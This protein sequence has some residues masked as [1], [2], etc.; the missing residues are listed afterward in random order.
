MSSKNYPKKS[1]KNFDHFE[2]ICFALKLPYD[3]LFN[4]N[5]GRVVKRTSERTKR[6][7][8]K[9]IVEGQL[10]TKTPNPNY[11]PGRKNY[12]NLDDEYLDEIIT[13]KER[14]NL[15]KIAKNMTRYVESDMGASLECIFTSKGTIK[16]QDTVNSFN[17]R[18]NNRATQQVDYKV[19]KEGFFIEVNH[20]D[21][22]VEPLNV[23][24]ENE[25][26]LFIN[27]FNEELEKLIQVQHN[28]Y[29]HTHLRLY[30]T[31]DG[32]RVG[33]QFCETY[34]DDDKCEIPV[35]NRIVW[36]TNFRKYITRLLNKDILDN[37]N[38]KMNG[39]GWR[40]LGIIGFDTCIRHVKCAINGHYVP[41]PDEL[42]DKVIVNVPN[43]D[44]RCIQ[45]TVI[46]AFNQKIIGKNSKEIRRYNNWWKK[47]NQFKVQ[48]HTILEFEEE[49]NLENNQPFIYNKSTLFRM[50]EYFDCYF[51]V[52][53][54]T[55]DADYKNC[56]SKVVSAFRIY[57]ESNDEDDNYRM[58]NKIIHNICLIVDSKTNDGH[59]CYIK[60][61]AL[62]CRKLIH[63]NVHKNNNGKKQIKCEKCDFR[64][65]SKKEM[66]IHKA[67]RHPDELTDS[68]RYVLIDD[69]NGYFVPDASIEFKDTKY[70]MIHPVMITFD[71]ETALK[72]TKEGITLHNP[73]MC[74][75]YVH[76]TIPTVKSEYRVFYAESL[77]H[78]DFI[79][80]IKYMKSIAYKTIK[81]VKSV[82]MINLDTISNL[83][84]YPEN[85]ERCPFCK[86]KF[87][88]KSRIIRHYA[89]YTGYYHNGSEMRYYNA[90]DIICNCC[91]KCNLQLE[92]SAMRIPVY[93]HN[94]SGYDNTLLI[95]ILSE[96][97]EELNIIPTAMDHF[98]QIQT[99]QL[100]FKDS[101][102]LISGSLRSLVQTFLGGDKSKYNATITSVKQWCKSYGIE[103]K[104]NY[105]DLLLQ[106]EPMFYNLV[107]SF[108]SLSTPTIPK[109]EDIYNELTSDLMSVEDYNH[110]KKLWTTFEIKNWK[111][112]Y[113]LYNILDATL[114]SDVL[115][116]FRTSCI[117]HFYVD[118]ANYM[119][120]PQMTYS[121]FL[122]TITDYHSETDLQNLANNWATYII[123]THNNEGLTHDE[124]VKY[125][126]DSMNDFLTYGLN[127]LRKSQIETF[128]KMM[129]SLRGG[130]TQIRTRYCDVTSKTQSNTGVMNKSKIEYMDLN[131]LYPGSMHRPFPYYVGYPK[132]VVNRDENPS[133]ISRKCDYDARWKI[134][135]ERLKHLDEI[136]GETE[137]MI[138][139]EEW[140]KYLKECIKE[141]NENDGDPEEIKRLEK[142]IKET[143][144]ELLMIKEE[145]V[146]GLY[147]CDESC[148]EAP[149][150]LTIDDPNEW[151]LE[152]SS[153]QTE[154]YFIECDIECP[155]ELHN[156][157]ND[158]P[159]FPEKNYGLQSQF[160]KDFAT[161]WNVTNK[162]T[163]TKKL[164][165]TLFNKKHYYCHYLML[166][167]GVQQGYR[168]TKI[169]NITPFKQAPFM[170]EYVSDLAR[171]RALAKTDVEKQLFK[172]LGNSLYGKC[173]YLGLN[174]MHVNVC[175]TYEQSQKIANNHSLD[176]IQD[177]E[178]YDKNL[179]IYKLRNPSRNITSPIF[180]GFTV[181]E[182]SKYIVYDYYYNV[183]KPNFDSV[184][185][186]GQ[187]TDSLIVKLT[188]N[189]NDLR[190]L[191][192]ADYMDFSEIDL[193]SPFGKRMTNYCEENNL[194]LK[195][196]MNNN[197]KVPGNIMKLEH[198]GWTIERFI[199]LRPKLYI[200]IDN[201]NTIHKASKGVPK[202]A[203][204]TTGE[205]F[206][207]DIEKYY[208]CLFPE[209][210][211]QAQQIGV[212]RHIVNQKLTLKTMSQEKC[213]MNCLDNKV[214]ICNDN[215]TT[216][217]WGHHSI[218]QSEN[219]QFKLLN[220][221]I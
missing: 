215:I 209:S 49:F 38:I 162:E 155:A 204:T 167:L 47:P 5:T 108:E 60:D 17:T 116:Q 109:L 50:E 192:L 74:S 4:W 112:Y 156:K 191:K 123:K 213:M 100:V 177:F 157:F 92:F 203:L 125:Y 133:E 130:I 67:A 200:L 10:I 169:H 61:P 152:Q 113:E 99:K 102:K 91:N 1:K 52:Y 186:L 165:C 59:A 145:Y 88:D 37:H 101:K 87:N 170:Y 83:D 26:Q 16:T 68:D 115:I 107:D 207:L 153:F 114:L 6:E 32:P 77:N 127:L 75:V 121:L 76:S 138:E 214:Y 93:A 118:P 190:I 178:L 148:E 94:S 42:S 158:L 22:R 11:K 72:P 110:M 7:M 29:M 210:S 41:T 196:F 139:D 212:F 173:L 189:D 78:K 33:K 174:K 95:H 111:M 122:K 164:V 188:S 126:F 137:D 66:F 150:L 56:C 136:S 202:N 143:E 105:I 198:Q 86:N 34:I 39:S 129:K 12:I 194:D 211:E 149:E 161:Q 9:F 30:F 31:K 55:V 193:K 160:I 219:D 206:K 142:E 2:A 199:G 221:I 141:V 44:Y 195:T 19:K 48:E 217:A 103:F 184:Q 20:V 172:L 53:K 218:P 70:M 181:L 79:P 104:D 216:Y 18:A 175:T 58:E 57:P 51:N 140:I 128:V 183:L 64:C 159:F 85:K 62:F 36:E 14:K 71:F 23:Y 8:K 208:H 80:M 65:M 106:K 171:K 117:N 146:R 132:I 163:K 3:K 63:E 90:G 43:T 28:G 15:T 21:V 89:H 134:L 82:E 154:G 180:V 131:N 151:I 185:L 27:T 84:E 119:T 144:K 46:Y 13:N 54:V 40:F 187:D 197:K 24:D 176:S 97:H 69:G 96:C 220:N 120:C 81:H 147:V 25:R 205:K 182:L 201:H 166:R 35:E 124:L 179:A 73:L 135:E 98:M 168:I 45:R